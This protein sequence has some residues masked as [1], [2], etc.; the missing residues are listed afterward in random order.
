MFS[1]VEGQAR[2]IAEGIAEDFAVTHKYADSFNTRTEIVDIGDGPHVAGI[3]ENDSDRAAAVEWGNSNDHRPH[4]V[5]GRTLG[6]L[7]G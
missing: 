2:P 7:G 6:A 1:I 4:R 3:L 5:L